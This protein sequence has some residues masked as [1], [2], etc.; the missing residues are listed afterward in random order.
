MVGFLLLMGRASKLTKTD[1]LCAGEKVPCR[2][3]RISTA[4][5]QNKALVVPPP[6]STA[7]GDERLELEQKEGCRGL[8]QQKRGPVIAKTGLGIYPTTCHF[9]GTFPSM[10]AF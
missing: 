1:S 8:H 9:H 5:S 3:A 10:E 4:A 6:T 2:R 7:Q